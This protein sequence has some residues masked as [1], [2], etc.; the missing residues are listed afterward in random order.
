MNPAFI[1]IPV[2]LCVDVVIVLAIGAALR[3]SLAPSL[4]PFPLRPPAPDAVSRNFQ[5][6]R[7]GLFNLGWCFHMAAD[8]EWFHIQPSA[9]ARLIRIPAASIPWTAL[10]DLRRARLS[11]YYHA[12]LGT[13]PIM[14]PAWCVKEAARLLDDGHD[15]G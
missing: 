2:V 9:F 13:T 4:A 8:A 1:I 7:F 14:L 15:P 6:L 3:A 10:T 11:A 12:R 5:S